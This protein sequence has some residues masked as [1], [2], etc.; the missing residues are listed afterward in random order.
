MDGR[1]SQFGSD[2]YSEMTGSDLPNPL[3]HNIKFPE[4]S[5]ETGLKPGRTS[6]TP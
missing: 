4:C 3:T 5:F 6:P 1:E 2:R